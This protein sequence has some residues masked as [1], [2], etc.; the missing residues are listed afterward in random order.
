MNCLTIKECNTMNANELFEIILAKAEE[1]GLVAKND[2]RT[3]VEPKGNAI[4]RNNLLD[5]S[6]NEGSAYFGFL[7][8]E[9]ETAGPYSDFSFVVFPDNKDDVQ[10]CV[11]CLGVGSSGFKNDYQLA[12]LPGLRRTYLKGTSNYT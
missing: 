7:S 4:I 12:S 9:E 1:Y 3:I 2:G 5:V 11:V 6:F 8:A 10:T